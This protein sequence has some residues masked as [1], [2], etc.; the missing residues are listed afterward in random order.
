M[1]RLTLLLNLLFAAT[2]FS[3]PVRIGGQL[4]PG[5]VNENFILFRLGDT[6]L[7]T[8]LLPGRPFSLQTDSLEA[9]FYQT[10]IAGLLYLKPGFRLQLK[11]FGANEYAFSGT[12]ALE[13]NCL[14]QARQQLARYIPAEPSGKLKQQ[15]YLM[16]AQSFVAGIDSFLAAGKKIVAK[17][18]DSLYVRYATMDLELLSRKLFSN[19][20]AN[21]GMNVKKQ[22]AAFAALEHN[23]DDASRFLKLADSVMQIARIRQLSPEERALVAKRVNTSFN[24]NDG[25]AYQL[26]PAYRNE[27]EQLISRNMSWNL[28]SLKPPFTQEIL[29]IAKRKTIDKNI[30]D[31][32]IR[33]YLHF[34]NTKDLIGATRDSAKLE[35]YLTE[36]Q[37]SNPEP[38]H[39][40][41]VASVYQRSLATANN[42]LAP[43]FDYTDI[44]GKKHRLSDLKGQYVYIDVWATWCAP[45]IREIPELKKLAADYAGKNIQFVSISVDLPENKATWKGFVKA[46]QLG[47]LQL[48]ADKAFQSE[49]KDAFQVS[50]IPRFL[51]IGPEGRIVSGDAA[52]PSD[53]T[54][55]EQLAS[56]NL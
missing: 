24:F 28:A 19:Y 44:S 43:D 18:N 2:A 30:K 17:S 26:L 12:G 47:G 34:E 45:C 55:R 31:S 52:R 36:Y 27:V 20:L 16:E 15:A 8:K 48:I 37:A 11:P 22:E 7:Q 54:L 50:A 56:L 3:Q 14:R 6:P 32:S 40:A 23:S 39:L 9:G 1:K 51:P 5:L 35:Q 29:L 41:K 38:R 53:A 46:K 49:F 25:V 10:N 33:A 21:A 42:R 4:Q 13:N